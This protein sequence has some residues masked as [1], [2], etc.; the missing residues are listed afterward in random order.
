M[1]EWKTVTRRQARV[2]DGRGRKDK[3]LEE[4]K[5]FEAREKRVNQRGEEIAN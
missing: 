1:R 3:E 4:L 5:M 2:R